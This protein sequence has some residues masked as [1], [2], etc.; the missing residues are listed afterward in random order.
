MKIKMYPLIERIVEDGADAGYRRAHKH[1][2]YPIE[3]TIKQ[4]IAQ[5][6][7]QGFD[8]HFEFSEDDIQ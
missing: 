1:T 2:D 8:E 7:M 5:Y 4:C 6:I 3:E